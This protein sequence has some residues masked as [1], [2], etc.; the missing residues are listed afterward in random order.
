MNRMLSAGAI[1]LALST[2]AA[3]TSAQARSLCDGDFERTPGGWISTPRCQEYEAAKVA[4]EMHQHLTDITSSSRDVTPDEFC[5]G[6][7]D[8]RVSTFCAAYKD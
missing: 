1:A 5:R 2:A 7:N 8:I 3:M 4:R 6:N